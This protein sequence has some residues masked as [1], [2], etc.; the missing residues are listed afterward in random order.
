MHSFFGSCS[1]SSSLIFS[2]F[3]III[4]HH[5]HN[6]SF[7][8]V[9]GSLQSFHLFPSFIFLCT[10]MQESAMRFITS[11]LDCRDIYISRYSP[12]AV[13]HAL[14]RFYG[15]SVHNH[16]HYH[17]HTISDLSTFTIPSYLFTYLPTYL[18]SYL[19]I[20]LPTCRF[21]VGAIIKTSV[22]VCMCLCLK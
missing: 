13:K 6:V 19:P 18:P 4:P 11:V 20:Y 7:S 15:K 5:N 9:A 8:L 1:P 14:E 3:I 21:P 2:S 17:Q 22:C 16:D 12:L 10:H